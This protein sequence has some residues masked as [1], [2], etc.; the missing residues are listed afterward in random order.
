MVL[1]RL[2]G[3]VLDVA[4]CVHTHLVIVSCVNIV[5]VWYIFEVVHLA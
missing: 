2:V 3:G 5:H 1:T 4:F